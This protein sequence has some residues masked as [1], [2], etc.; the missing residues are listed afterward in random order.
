VL[1]SPKKRR[2]LATT[3]LEPGLLA[4]RARYKKWQAAEKVRRQHRARTPL[5]TTRSFQDDGQ[6]ASWFGV[7]SRVPGSPAS[8][9]VRIAALLNDLVNRGPYVADYL[10]CA[11]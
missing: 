11:L 5:D 7:T 4:I 3:D 1:Q 2:P 6:N 8:S 9:R 10:G